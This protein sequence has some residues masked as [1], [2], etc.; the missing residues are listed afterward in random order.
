MAKMEPPSSNPILGDLRE[1]HLH[2]AHLCVIATTEFMFLFVDWQAVLHVPYVRRLLV[3][4][5]IPRRS[6]KRPTTVCFGT[7]ERS[8][9]AALPPLLAAASATSTYA[10]HTR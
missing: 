3:A 9:A 2:Q 7:V 5:V 6:L 4:S 10:T 1:G 8:A